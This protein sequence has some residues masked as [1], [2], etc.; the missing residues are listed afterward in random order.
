VRLVP[1]ARRLNSVALT[2]YK[3]FVILSAAAR[4]ANEHV[5]AARR[6][7]TYANLAPFRLARP[8]PN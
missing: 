5:L 6:L 4:S 1:G 3:H 8:R 7:V 2:I